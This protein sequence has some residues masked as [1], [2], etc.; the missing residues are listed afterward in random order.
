MAG[1]LERA[2][3]PPD[4]CWTCKTCS[5]IRRSPNRGM[6]SRRGKTDGKPSGPYRKSD[7]A[8]GFA[9]RQLSGCAGA[10][11]R[12]PTQCWPTGWACR[13]T[14]SCRLRASNSSEAGTVDPLII[15]ARVN[16]Y[17]TRKKNPTCRGCRAR[18]RAN[19]TECFEAG[20]SIVHFHGRDAG[21]APE[22]G[23]KR[24]AIRCRCREPRRSW[25]HPSLGY[26]DTSILVES[27]SADDSN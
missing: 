21:G 2:G 9:G 10:W 14:R 22:T 15:E 7:Q 19:A 8:V 13:P 25:C 16:E 12:T 20:A 3:F 6:R 26:L 23:S 18:S 17:A 24:A 4:R 1:L 5:I 11:A 27:A